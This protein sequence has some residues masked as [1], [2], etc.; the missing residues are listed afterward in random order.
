MVSNSGGDET[1]TVNVTVNSVNDAP[2]VDD[3]E[4]DIDENSVNTTSVGTV[5]ASD[6]EVP[7]EGQTLSYAITAGN[8]GI[9]FA[10]DSATGEMIPIEERDGAEVLDI[11]RNGKPL[12]PEG[13]QA[14]N[15]A[16]DITPS[17]LIT[18]IVT[19]FGVIEMPFTSNLA[20]LESLRK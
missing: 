4:F 13:A 6:I 2:V 8:T 20:K 15:P 17:R 14:R 10:I 18:G 7:G 1:A 9:A 3:H 16:F 5:A 11:Q 19:E 12:S